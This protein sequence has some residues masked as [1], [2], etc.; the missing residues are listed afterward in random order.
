MKLLIETTGQFMLVDFAQG[1]DIE[2]DIPSVVKRSVFIDSMIS[3]GKVRILG[4]VTDLATNEAL[5][6]AIDGSKDMETA[7]AAFLAEFDPKPVTAKAKA[8]P[9]NEK[10]S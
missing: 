1:V 9:K 10:S 6:E 3:Q 4:E 5:R 8:Q 2:A 7:V